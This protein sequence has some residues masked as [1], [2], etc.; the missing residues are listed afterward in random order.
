MDVDAPAGPPSIVNQ[1]LGRF[2]LWG[3][4]R[5]EGVDLGAPRARALTRLRRRTRRVT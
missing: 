5:V 3:F 1:H 2:A 4:G